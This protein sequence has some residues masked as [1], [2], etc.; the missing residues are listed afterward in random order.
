MVKKLNSLSLFFPALNDAQILPELIKKADVV[1]KICSLKYEIIVINDGST[2][3]TKKVLE[4]LE[5]KYP[6][7]SAFHHKKNEGYGSALIEGFDRAKY[8]WV[9]YTDGDGQYDPG[10]LIRLVEEIDEKTD[11][12]NGYKLSREDDVTRK[13]TGW[14]YN[15]LLQLIYHPPISDVDCDFRLIRGAVMKKFKLSSHS[16]LTCL[17]LAMKLKKVG[18]LFK[19]TGVSHHKRRY[20]RSQFFNLKHLLATLH[21]H[22]VFYLNQFGTIS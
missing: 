8:E 20:G 14:M 1:A 5:K 17:E 10:E 16:G 3:N 13:I 4:D 18:A 11:V 22:V 21:E 12:V 19:E 7:L 6:A 9:F 15:K 2:D